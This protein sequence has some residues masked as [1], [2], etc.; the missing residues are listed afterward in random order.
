MSDRVF[1][2]CTE[3]DTGVWCAVVVNID[4]SHQLHGSGTLAQ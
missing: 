1:I 3:Q 2:L 4:L